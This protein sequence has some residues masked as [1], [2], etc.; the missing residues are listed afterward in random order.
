MLVEFALTEMA[1]V[2]VRILQ[3]YDRLES[4][5]EVNPGLK[6]DIVLSPAQGVKVAFFASEKK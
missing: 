4:R 2:V 1:Y 6:A 5:T 3:T